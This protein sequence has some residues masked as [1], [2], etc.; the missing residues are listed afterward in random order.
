MQAL[1]DIR[2]GLTMGLVDLEDMTT[3]PECLAEL[4]FTYSVFRFTYAW[5]TLYEVAFSSLA[6]ALDAVGIGEE[7]RGAGFPTPRFDLFAH[8]GRRLAS[9]W[10]GPT[11]SNRTTTTIRR[12]ELYR[13]L[14]DAVAARGV[15]IEYGKALRDADTSGGVRARFS[16]GS[17]VEGDLLVGADGLHS[18]ARGLIDPAAPEPRYTGLLN[19]GGFAHDATLPPGTVL[20]PGVMEFRFGRRCFLGMTLAPDGDVWWFANP[21]ST[22]ELGP[23]ELAMLDGPEWRRELV[24]L[25]DGDQIPARELIEATTLVFPG[26][27]TY[28]LPRV[29]RWHRDR[30]VIIG[31][32]SHAISPTSGQGASLAI[33]DAVQLARALRDLP[34]TD[35]LDTFEL[36]R[37]TRVERAVAQGARTGS[38]KAVGPVGRLVRDRVVMP[39]IAHTARR[40]DPATDWLTGHRIVWDEP[41][42]VRDRA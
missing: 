38:R 23:D 37:R 14:R 34:V 19:T 29:P 35:A 21:F 2:E 9:F 40:H 4:E 5:G 15:R 18:V 32:A 1:A 26:W 27:N 17:T 28:D 42:S 13:I 33:E 22:R 20:E 8:T 6:D 12:A 39:V 10:A 11:D 3:D 31:D 24:A 25:F 16:D 30:M 36:L 7:L 41:V